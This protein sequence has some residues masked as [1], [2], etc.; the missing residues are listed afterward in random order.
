MR[1]D[2]RAVVVVTDHNRTCRVPCDQCGKVIYAHDLNAQGV[3]NSVRAERSLGGS[4]ESWRRDNRMRVR[5][6]PVA[7]PCLGMN[8]A[9]LHDVDEASGFRRPRPT[10]FNGWSGVVSSSARAT[11]GTAER[12][13]TIEGA[14]MRTIGQLSAGELRGARAALV[15]LA[16]ALPTNRRRLYRAG[17]REEALKGL[18][19]VR[20]PSIRAREQ[21][22]GK[23]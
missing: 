4:N 19:W 8:L 3:P 7:L 16:T 13:G 22:A 6:R 10:S 11:R 21:K 14:V 2:A 12:G 1:G 15:L 20:R 9:C 23:W 18:S 17:P 5:A